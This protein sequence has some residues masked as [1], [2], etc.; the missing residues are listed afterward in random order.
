MDP[1]S[2]RCTRMVW[3]LHCVLTCRIPVLAAGARIL[4]RPGGAW[5]LR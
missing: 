5:E 2:A 1:R 4:A 3:S